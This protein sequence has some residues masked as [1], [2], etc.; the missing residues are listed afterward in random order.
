MLFHKGG[1][2]SL[3]S[4]A[5]WLFAPCHVVVGLV[6]P[7]HLAKR[8]KPRVLFALLHSIIIFCI[9]SFVCPTLPRLVAYSL[10]HTHNDIDILVL[11]VTNS[12]FGT[13]TLPKTHIATTATMDAVEIQ[14]QPAGSSAPAS[15]DDAF[16]ETV[17]RL[18]DVWREL[19]ATEA[20]KAEKLEEIRDEVSA[21]VCC[22]ICPALSLY[23][24]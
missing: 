8:Y 12:Y 20:E 17:A 11:V 18:Q 10:L 7:L 1:A 24:G 22:A 16:A 5:R 14:V 4:I 23:W 3:I 2:G 21:Y 19:G 6:T 13:R 9:K 15:L